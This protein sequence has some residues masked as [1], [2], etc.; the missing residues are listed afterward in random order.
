MKSL[1]SRHAFKIWSLRVISG[2]KD[3]CPSPLP[4]KKKPLY[5]W[6][7]YF[8]FRLVAWK[9]LWLTYILFNLIA[10][11]YCKFLSIDCWANS[12]VKCQFCQRKYSRGPLWSGINLW[13]VMEDKKILFLFSSSLEW[14]KKPVFFSTRYV[15]LFS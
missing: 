10:N 1:F 14:P 6:F 9:N 15:V 4:K 7:L 8:V 3:T 13:K 2:Y 11:S 5:S 12:S